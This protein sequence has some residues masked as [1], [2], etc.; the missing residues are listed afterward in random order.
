MISKEAKGYS[1]VCHG[2]KKK[3]TFQAGKFNEDTHWSPRG[4]DSLLEDY[5]T[6]HQP[7]GP[8]DEKKGEGKCQEGKRDI[9]FPQRGMEVDKRSLGIWREVTREPRRT[10]SEKKEGG[11]KRE[12]V[13]S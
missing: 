13:S 7:G 3:R 12:K 10:L 1:G 4:G 5:R 9:V 6:R 11:L 2:A 8:V